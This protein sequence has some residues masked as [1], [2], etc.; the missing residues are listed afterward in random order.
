MTTPLEGLA[1][2]AKDDPFF[3][4]CPLYWYA[5][6]ESLSDEAL[7]R[8]LGCTPETLVNVRLCGTPAA[9][10]PAFNRDVTAIAQR[11]GLNETALTKA[12]R[13]GTVVLQLQSAAQPLLAARD[14]KKE[15]RP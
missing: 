11:F 1:A 9:K 8:F 4:A 12:V 15:K 6:S 14:R 10:Q 3:L 2:W 7:A 13:R 5:R